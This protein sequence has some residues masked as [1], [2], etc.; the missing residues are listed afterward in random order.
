[1]RTNKNVEPFKKCPLNEMA[2]IFSLHR[3]YFDHQY[4]N[5]KAE[6]SSQ[7]KP[8]IETNQLSSRSLC[9]CAFSLS[10]NWSDKCFCYWQYPIALCMNIPAVGSF[11]NFISIDE[12]SIGSNTLHHFTLTGDLLLGHT[13][14]HRTK[15]ICSFF[16]WWQMTDLFNALKHLSTTSKCTLIDSREL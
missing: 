6:K 13:H 16:N 12:L 7:R 14:S 15:C 2:D 1:M 11:K 4:W 10:L 8:Q 9:A 5:S 3:L